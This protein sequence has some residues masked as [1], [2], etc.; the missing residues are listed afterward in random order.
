MV[1]LALD[2]QAVSHFLLF[3]L[4]IILLKVT[5]LIN[6]EITHWSLLKVDVIEE[7]KSDLTTIWNCPRA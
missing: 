6:G 7:S 4:Q 3:L 1:V 2:I 5:C